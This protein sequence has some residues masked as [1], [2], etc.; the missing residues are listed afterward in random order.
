L[1]GNGVVV[2]SSVGVGFGNGF[3]DVPIE[4]LQEVGV[5]CFLVGVGGPG[6]KYVPDAGHAED[7]DGFAHGIF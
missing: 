5:G 6:F 3:V 4:G 2:L 1:E 7:V